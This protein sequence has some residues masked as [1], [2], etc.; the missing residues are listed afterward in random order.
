MTP[1]A[2]KRFEDKYIPVTESG[3][4]I[5]TGCTIRS[6]YARFNAGNG[7]RNAHA[8]ALEHWKNI[9]VPKGMHTDHLCRVRCCVN[10]DHL[11]VV[12]PAE[13]LRRGVGL[14]AMHSKRTHCPKGHAYE[15]TNCIGEVD[16]GYIH[17]RCRICKNAR[18]FAYNRRTRAKL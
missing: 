7:T 13:N 3:C 10:P 11:E 8:I 17:R 5:W 14:S 16:R 18:Q 4:W 12:T 2:L 1:Q 6:G 9:T 15:G